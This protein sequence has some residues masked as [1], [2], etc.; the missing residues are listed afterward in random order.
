MLLDEEKGRS[1]NRLSRRSSRAQT[2]TAGN[3]KS[4]VP[5]VRR[6]ATRRWLTIVAGIVAILG[7][8]YG[9]YQYTRWQVLPSAAMP[10]PRSAAA[11]P[12][13]RPR[14]PG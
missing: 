6:G 2:A 9:G 5:S 1:L 3:G 13:R 10:T 7:G 14:T 8:A 12:K 11:E 4:A